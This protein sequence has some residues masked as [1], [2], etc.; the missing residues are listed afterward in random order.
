MFSSKS[1]KAVEAVSVL[2]H[3]QQLRTP[4]G[5]AL[6]QLAELGIGGE[7][8]AMAFGASDAFP[9]AQLLHNDDRLTEAMPISLTSLPRPP[10]DPVQSLLA[11]GTSAGRLF[12]FGA[13]GV[14]VEWDVGLPSKI[15]HLAWKSGSGFL[16]V[17]GESLC[18]GRHRTMY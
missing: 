11:V 1:R 8:T 4:N 12:V 3:T 6:G 14:Q 13:P 18:F 5:W 16:C 2:D 15:R 10:T 9:H 17:V 7:L